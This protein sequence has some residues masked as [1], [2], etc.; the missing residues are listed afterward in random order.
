MDSREQMTFITVTKY[1]S[2]IQERRAEDYP[3][4]ES[5]SLFDYEE[6]VLRNNAFIAY[7][8][9]LIL[10]CVPKHDKKQ[11]LQKIKSTFSISHVNERKGQ[12]GQLA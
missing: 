1:M 6:F 10:M 7:S 2:K 4:V 9:L 12:H 5:L 8:S 3:L 11:S